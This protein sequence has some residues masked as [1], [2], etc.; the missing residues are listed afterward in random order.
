L[1]RKA[2]ALALARLMRPTSRRQSP[3]PV[4]LRAQK[5]PCM[6]QG[7]VRGLPV[8]IGANRVA[9]PRTGLKAVTGVPGIAPPAG[10]SGKADGASTVALRCEA[11]SVRIRPTRP[12]A[13]F[14]LRQLLG[15]LAEP[16]HLLSQRIAAVSIHQAEV[17]D[18]RSRS[19]QHPA[20][21]CARPDRVKRRLLTV[22]EEEPSEIA[23]V[24]IKEVRLEPLDLSLFLEL[25]VV[26]DCLLE[27]LKRKLLAPTHNLTPTKE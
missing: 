9:G 26:A 25:A 7:M 17:V 16:R 15:H 13:L 8:C 22:K 24:R 20:E 21:F 10:G 12:T 11:S 18:H 14:G 4:A 1:S 5:Q 27:D 23:A 3:A 6:C 2:L 19:H